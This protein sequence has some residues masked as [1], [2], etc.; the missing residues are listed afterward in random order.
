MRPTFIVSFYQYSHCLDDL[1]C[2]RCTQLVDIFLSYKQA[3][4]A[5]AE[6]LP[7]LK[8]LGVPIE[9]PFDYFAEMVKTDD[10]MQKVGYPFSKDKATVMQSKESIF[11]K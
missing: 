1:T 8:K 3:Q 6:A 2:Q 10:H 5:F 9:R 4:M 7:Q 11:I